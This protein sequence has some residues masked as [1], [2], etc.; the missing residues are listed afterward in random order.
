MHAPCT[1][2]G[3]TS[4]TCFDTDEEYLAALL[5]ES[6]SALG[7]LDAAIRA[8]HSIPGLRV[9][10]AEQAAEQLRRAIADAEREEPDH[11]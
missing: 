4:C 2:C 9:A 10:G 1:F 11:A 7:A 8:S 5:V 6:K 3:S